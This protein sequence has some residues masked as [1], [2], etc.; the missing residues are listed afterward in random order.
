MNG[1]FALVMLGLLT[2]GGL[3]SS[4]AAAQAERPVTL[5]IRG[6]AMLPTFD[7]ADAAD[8]GFGGGVGIGYRLG[9]KNRLMADF[10]LGVH[11][12]PAPGFD[13]NTYHVMAKYGRD[14]MRRKNLV[15]TLNLGAG[16][17]TFGG[18][19]P[20]SKTYFAINAGAKLGIEVSPKVEVL[21]SPQ[22]DIAFTKKADLATTNAWVWPLS[23]GI[24]ARL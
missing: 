21:L 9:E 7:I 8:L 23:V 10:D 5:E 16:A 14:V 2:A 17:V 13:I 22:G 24:R 20:S 15:L 1:R 3:I 12:T 11:G 18:D 4:E 19:L 6:T